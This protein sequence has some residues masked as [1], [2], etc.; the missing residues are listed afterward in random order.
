MALAS[1]GDPDAGVL[2]DVAHLEHTGAE[3]LTDE[4]A[5]AVFLIAHDGKAD[6]LGAAARHGSAAGEA[7]QAEGRA[8][9]GR[10]N[11]QGQGD[12]HDDRD[13]DAHEE[14]SLFG[15]PHDEGAHLTCGCADGG[16][17]EHRE[18][19]AGKRWSPAG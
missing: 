18:A 16:G 1:W 2:Y 4:A 7:R 14:G 3:A 9:G 13:E 6:H 11:G 19:D 8:D 17:D 12:A 5:D 15:G 10:G